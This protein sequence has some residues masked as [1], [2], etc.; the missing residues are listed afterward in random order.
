[1]RQNRKLAVSA[2]A[3][4]LI[5]GILG[6]GYLVALGVKGMEDTISAGSI[7]KPAFPMLGML[8]VVMAV[9][10]LVMVCALP[11]KR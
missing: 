5:S 4:D 6:V 11:K 8:A 1:M 10:T 3:I 7:F 2:L 9:S